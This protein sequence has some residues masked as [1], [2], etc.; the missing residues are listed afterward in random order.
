MADDNSGGETD[1][2]I[3]A[4]LRRC[5][6]DLMALPGVTGIGVGGR[7]D[8]AHAQIFTT[9]QPAEEVAAEVRRLL[10]GLSVEFVGMGVPVADTTKEE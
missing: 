6:A 3:S 4:A 8:D 9:G 10:D 7:P 5:E 2:D 1:L